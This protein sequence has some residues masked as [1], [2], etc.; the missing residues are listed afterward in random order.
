MCKPL[1]QLHLVHEQVAHVVIGCG[2]WHQGLDRNLLAGSVTG[3]EVDTTH[4]SGAK[5]FDEFVSS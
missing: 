5:H 1:A 4:A 3:A 2:L